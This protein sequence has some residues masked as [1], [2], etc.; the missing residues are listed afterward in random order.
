MEDEGSTGIIVQ[1]RMGSTRLPGKVLKEVCGRP[2]IVHDLE[3]MKAIE[4]VDRIVLATTE[5]E[6]DDALVDV[7]REYDRDVA[8][9][10]GDAEDVL[11]RFYRASEE[12]DLDVIVRITSDCP[13]LD[14]G[15]STTVVEEFLSHPCDYCCNNMP[16]TLPHGFDTE[17]FS[18][19][20]LERAWDEARAPEEREHVTTYIRDHPELFELRTVRSAHD[21]SGLR[22]TLDYP[23]DLEFIERVY[24][25]LYEEG[26]IFT[27]RDLMGLLRRRPELL[28]INAMHT[29]RRR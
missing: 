13:L 3:R 9:Y 24:E 16:P 11:D 19:T 22:F 5:L 26:G 8:V 14:P 2:I 1:A 12:F 15:M 6:E 21:M 27:F 10:R 29:R 23:E 25:E 7:V 17:A 28:R 20:A 4:N 18:Y